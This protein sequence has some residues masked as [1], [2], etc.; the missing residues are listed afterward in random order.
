MAAILRFRSE[1]SSVL[2]SDA[3][4]LSHVC[5]DIIKNL[6]QDAKELMRNANSEV[7][8]KICDFIEK[9]K[10]SSPVMSLG[11][12]TGL[13][14]AGVNMQDHSISFSE[15]YGTIKDNTNCL[16]IL[17]PSNC[18]TLDAGL[19]SLFHQFSAQAVK[20]R[21][22]L[23]GSCSMSMLKSWFI[24]SSPGPLVVLIRE[25]ESFH[26]Q[27]LRDLITVCSDNSLSFHKNGL[28][29][30]F[31]LAISTSQHSLKGLMQTSS[32]NKLQV[33]SPKQASHHSRTLLFVVTA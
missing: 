32:L 11:I 9:Q 29:F 14:L 18:K 27:V 20:C 25:V 28:P 13:I 4:D 31:L 7:F 5:I 1:P 23:G 3:H 6:E 24:E 22:N 30:V 17:H 33:F 21:S 8:S 26:P 10:L 16:A 19:D 15:L 12:P 2:D